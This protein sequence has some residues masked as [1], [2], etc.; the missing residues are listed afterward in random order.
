M[1]SGGQD[2]A[3]QKLASYTNGLIGLFHWSFSTVIPSKINVAKSIPDINIHLVEVFN[4]LVTCQLAP[5]PFEEQL[6][7]RGRQTGHRNKPQGKQTEEE[8]TV[9]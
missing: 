4:Q 7:T 1:G 2:T 9:K 5:G 3:L 8:W 6:C